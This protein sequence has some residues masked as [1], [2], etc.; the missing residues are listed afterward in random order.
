[1]SISLCYN[2]L[3]YILSSISM[4]EIRKVD[5]M[6]YAKFSGA[7]GFVLGL[8]AGLMTALFSS[9]LSQAGVPGAGGAGIAAIII[10]PIM[11]GI[12]G[13]I[14][15]YVGALVYNMVAERAGGIKVELVD[16]KEA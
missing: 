6:S 5:P 12:G 8:F 1:M 4:K 11:Y 16:S 7:M 15:G 2:Q 9:A 13:F 14:G 3:I 10:T